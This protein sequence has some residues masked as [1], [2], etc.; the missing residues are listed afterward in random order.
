MLYSQ[1]LVDQ[2]TTNEICRRNA[3]LIFFLAL[4]VDS[5]LLSGNKESCVDGDTSWTY[6]VRR[7]SRH[8]D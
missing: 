2:D 1:E 8:V 6:A 3:R 4:A 7:I 5:L